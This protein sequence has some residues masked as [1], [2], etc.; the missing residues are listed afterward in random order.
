VAISP[1]AIAAFYGIPYI[2]KLKMK[3]GQLGIV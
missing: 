3:V 1:L 2:E